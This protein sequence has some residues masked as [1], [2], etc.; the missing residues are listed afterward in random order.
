M[1]AHL[2]PARLARLAAAVSP[3]LLV[4]THVYPQLDRATIPGAIAA[5]GWSGEVVVASDGL[6]LP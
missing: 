1:D 2:T 4:A 6:V 5:A 3:R